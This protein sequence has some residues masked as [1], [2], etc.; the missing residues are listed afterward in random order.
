MGAEILDS[1]NFV[2]LAA[3][4]N[5]LFAAN[6]PAQWLVGNLVRCAGDVPRIFGYIPI[7]RSGVIA[8]MDPLGGIGC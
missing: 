4:K 6:L 8:F 3:I 5:D 2:L 7:S 1:R